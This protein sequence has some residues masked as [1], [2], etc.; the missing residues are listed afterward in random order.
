[1]AADQKRIFV[2]CP[3]RATETRTVEQHLRDAEAYAQTV[4]AAGHRPIVPHLWLVGH[5]DEESSEERHM[6][7]EMDKAALVLCDEVWA[8][9]GRIS[10]GMAGEIEL[11]KQQGIPTHTL[12]PSL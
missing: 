7:M 6:G 3:V 8:F 2:C 11:A 1:M 5:L 12:W 9:G 4:R 10:S